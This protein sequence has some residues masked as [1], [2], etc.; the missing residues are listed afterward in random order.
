MSG[1]T[2]LNI[3]G[4]LF[5]NNKRVSKCVLT[6]SKFKMSSSGQTRTCIEF[7]DAFIW[8]PFEQPLKRRR[9]FVRFVLRSDVLTQYLKSHHWKVQTCE[10]QMEQQHINRDGIAFQTYWNWCLPCKIDI[11]CY[12]WKNVCNMMWY[13]AIEGEVQLFVTLWI[14]TTVYTC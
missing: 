9:I 8:S 1:W 2:D 12:V 7:W 10:Y 13:W 11:V 4:S 14:I 6:M 3:L 5:P